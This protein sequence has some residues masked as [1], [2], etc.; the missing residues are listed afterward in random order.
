MKTLHPTSCLIFFMTFLLGLV[1]QSQCILEVNYTV[2]GLTVTVNAA[3]SGAEQGIGQISWGDP[4]FSVTEGLSGSFT[5]PDLGF[6]VIDIVYYDALDTDCVATEFIQ[7]DFTVPCT[8]S[9][10][11]AITGN[12]VTVVANGNGAETEE[13]FVNWDDGILEP[14][15]DLVHLYGADGVYNVCINYTDPNTPETCNTQYCEEVHVCTTPLAISFEIGMLG[16]G[17][18]VNASGTGAFDPIYTIF[19]G[20]GSISEGNAGG[21]VYD[22]EG[23]Y[24]LC[25]QYTDG[26]SECFVQECEL[27]MVSSVMESEAAFQALTVAPNPVKERLR[28]HAVPSQAG[29]VVIRLLDVSGRNVQTVY[30]G[31]AGTSGVQLSADVSA[32]PAGCYLLEAAGPAGSSTQRVIVQ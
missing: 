13:Y 19:W 6:Y 27:L 22:T 1:A 25:L 4:A 30:S 10:S 5:Y 23:T 3:G 28:I 14:G 8:V 2:D 21:H 29:D 11:I 16:K 7:I 18:T 9:A 15:S 32:L 20:D 12:E 17:V 31:N 24:N 26:I